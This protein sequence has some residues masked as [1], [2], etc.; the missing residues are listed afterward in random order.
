MIKDD[1]RFTKL[2]MI[3]ESRGMIDSEKIFTKG[4]LKKISLPCPRCNYEGLH[5]SGEMND[6]DD[7]QMVFDFKTHKFRCDEC[8]IEYNPTTLL[9]YLWRLELEFQKQSGEF[10]RILDKL[11]CE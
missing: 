9:D 7:I 6:P 8:E 11:E 10:V 3:A 2:K 5:E 1:E 4:V